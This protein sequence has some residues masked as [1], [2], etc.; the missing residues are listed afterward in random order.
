VDETL[1][2]DQ[3]AEILERCHTVQGDLKS[4]NKSQVYILTNEAAVSLLQGRAARRCESE[5]E[6]ANLVWPAIIEM[7]SFAWDWEGQIVDWT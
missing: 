7:H 1:Q 6:W 5:V 2:I 3:E 4:E